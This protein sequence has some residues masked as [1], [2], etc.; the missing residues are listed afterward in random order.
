MKR[1]KQQHS[2]TTAQPPTQILYEE[3]KCNP[4]RSNV[5]NAK[6]ILLST[7][8]VE[9][10]FEHLTTVKEN[11]EAGAKKAAETRKKKSKAK[12]SSEPE[13]WRCGTCGRLYEEETEE[14]EVWI[15]CSTCKVWLHL[16]CTENSEVPDTFICQSCNV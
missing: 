13:E 11:R 9:L 8:D 2:V 7:D 4:R 10:W 14:E 3:H 15:E 1:Y 6:A 5:D 16:M 12:K